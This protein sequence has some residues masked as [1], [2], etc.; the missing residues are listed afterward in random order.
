MRRPTSGPSVSATAM[1]RLSSTTGEAVRRASSA[2]QSR[3]VSDCNEAIAC[4]R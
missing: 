4:R 2:P 3:G 1:A